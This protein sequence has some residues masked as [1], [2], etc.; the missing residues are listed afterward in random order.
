MHEDHVGGV[1]LFPG[2]AQVGAQS[3]QAADRVRRRR[4]AVHPPPEPRRKIWAPRGG[5]RA[6]RLA[7]ERASGALC[8]A[9][10]GHVHVEIR[11]VRGD[12]HITRIAG[13][14]QI[15]ARP[16]HRQPIQRCV[17]L[18]E[19]PVPLGVQPGGYLG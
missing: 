1:T 4:R 9:A 19:P 8:F 6:K 14:A 5:G 3:R 12:D 18:D 17:G 7:H 16:H 13:N 10:D 2:C 15:R 11:V